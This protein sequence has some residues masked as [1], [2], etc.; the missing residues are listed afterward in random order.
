MYTHHTS[1]GQI[2]IAFVGMIMAL[3]LFMLLIVNVS[4]LSRER[5]RMQ[6]AADASALAMATFQARALN[7][8]ADRNFILKYPSGDPKKQ[9]DPQSAF[10]FPGI[11][12]IAEGLFIFPSKTDFEKYVKV[13]T[14]YQRQQE[15]FFELY[16]KLIPTIGETYIK[17]N[18]TKALKDTFTII[19]FDIKQQQITVLYLDWERGGPEGKANQLIDGWMIGGENFLYSF[20]QLKKT[21]EVWGE[22]F[23]YKT[24]AMGAVIPFSGKL[25]PEPYPQY[26]SCLTQTDEND[27]VLH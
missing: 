5:I 10:S 18:D 16:A 3:V 11:D 2:V 24:T 1:R 17:K 23:N 27:E 7:A 25:W 8:I 20:V 15:K 19:P 21:V 9:W 4:T 6:T 26:K 12:V 13:I 22:T 14:P